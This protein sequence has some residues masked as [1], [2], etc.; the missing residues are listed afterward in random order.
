M[1]LQL[2]TSYTRKDAGILS[3]SQQRLY[4]LGGVFE[5]LSDSE[6]LHL[7]LGSGTKNH[8]LEEVV[9]EI[10][11]LKNEYGL[12]GLTPEFLCNRVS[13]FTQRR[14]ESFLAGLE[15]GKRIYTQETA[16]RLVIRSP[17]DSAN[18]LM[19]MRFL[20]Q[21]HFVALY[22]NAKYEVIGKKTI[23]IGSLNSSIVHPREIVRP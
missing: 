21:E 11:E 15:L 5:S 20:K 12:K 16:I 6:V 19:D 18:I 13:G 3:E 17:E 4:E 22:L 9:N 23:F 7:I 14:A 2:A 10:L 8:P 1:N